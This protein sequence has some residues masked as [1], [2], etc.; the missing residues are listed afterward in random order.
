MIE[1]ARE[2]Y[3]INFSCW[4]NTTIKVNFINALLFRGTK[5]QIIGHKL[6]RDKDCLF[7]S[8]CSGVEHFLRKIKDQLPD[9]ELVIN[10]RD[11]AQV[12]QYFGSAM[13]VFSFSKVFIKLLQHL[14]MYT[15]VM[16]LDELVDILFWTR[17]QTTTTLHIQLGL[18]G[19]AV[20]PSAFIRE[21][22]VDGTSIESLLT[23]QPRLIHGARSNRKPSLE[24]REQVRKE[25]HWFFYLASSPIWLTLN[26]QRI[27]HGNPMQ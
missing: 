3:N 9:M 23:R 1:K 10:T 16:I 22:S 4:R 27:K 17:P 6:Y 15:S 7:P 20:Q 26:T 11:W 19:R 14:Y 18:F 21:V 25:I 24:D 2:K 8:R 12:N 5:Y 13:P